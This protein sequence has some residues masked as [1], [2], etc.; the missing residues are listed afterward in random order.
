MPHNPWHRLLPC[1]LNMAFTRLSSAC[2]S[3]VYDCIS[4]LGAESSSILSVLCHLQGC[5]HRAC[6]RHVTHCC[7]YHQA[8]TALTSKSVGR[9]GYCI[10]S[11]LDHRF[12]CFGNWLVAPWM[13]HRVHSV[14]CCQWVYDRICN[15]HSCRPG[16][17]AHGHF[18]V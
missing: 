5:Y 15:Q 13:A 11:S 6:C 14:A 10:C 7:E 16:S 4:P 12:H 2:F 8:C 18:G 9:S 3:T 1:L 17:W